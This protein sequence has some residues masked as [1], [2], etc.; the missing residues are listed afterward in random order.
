[1][2]PCHFP[3]LFRRAPL[4]LRRPAF[5][6]QCI[7]DR[8]AL[9]LRVHDHRIE[10]DLRDFVGMV[11]GKARQPHHELDESVDIGRQRAAMGPSGTGA[12]AMSPSASTS[13]PPRPT[14]SNGPQVGSRLIPRMTSRPGGAIGCTRTPSMDAAAAWR[15]ALATR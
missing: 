1:M 15:L 10:I 6:N 2:G 7:D 5:D 14:I 11:R 4:R 9:A 12:S 13:T 8:N 3:R